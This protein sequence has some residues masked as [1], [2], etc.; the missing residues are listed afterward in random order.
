MSPRAVQHFIDSG[1]NETITRAVT[2]AAISTFEQH[3][4]LAI[5]PRYL[6]VLQEHNVQYLA[7]VLVRDRFELQTP[8]NLGDP[9][10]ETLQKQD[11]VLEIL[12]YL[13]QIVSNPPFDNK[14]PSE[15]DALLVRAHV[16]GLAR[17]NNCIT[18]QTGER[19]LEASKVQ[20]QQQAAEFGD[21]S[22]AGR[23]VDLAFVHK[24]IELSNIEFK[25]PG[26]GA[27]DITVQCRKNIRLGRCLQEQHREYG[28]QEPS[29]IMGDVAGFIGIFYQLAKMGEVWVAGKTSPS[30]VHLP[31]TQGELEMFLESTSLAQIF[32]FVEHLELEAPKIKRQQERYN[33]ATD[34]G[35]FAQAVES[36]R[37]TTPPPK[38]KSFEQNVTFSP[39]RKHSLH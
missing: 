33:R 1:G 12:Q 27:M 38:R 25:R 9:L 6:Q 8:Y 14:D 37:P 10:P 23:K 26:I 7:W 39:R 36:P 32:N 15:I 13:C 21:L 3:A 31:T 29:V 4:C 2:R 18:L 20:R 24:G 34:I 11:K 35:F 30:T 5:L 19:M 28:V 16:F 22:D 17:S